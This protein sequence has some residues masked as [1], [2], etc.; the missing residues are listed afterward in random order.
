M[1]SSFLRQAVAVNSDRHAQLTN[2]LSGLERIPDELKEQTSKV[3]ELQAQLEKCEANVAAL[4]ERTRNQRRN[5]DPGIIPGGL[6]LFRG[7]KE[8]EKEKVQEQTN[9]RLF[10][11]ARVEEN[12]ERARKAFLEQSLSKEQAVKEGL[13]VKMKDYD[14][15]VGQLDAMYVIFNGPTPGYPK[16][17][18]LEQVVRASFAVVEQARTYFNAENK[19]LEI[20][21]RSERT[22]KE[23][24][25]KL[26]DAIY[27]ATTAMVSG[28][29]T[30]QT[31][32]SASLKSAHSLAQKAQVLVR[33]A[34]QLSPQIRTLETPSIVRELPVRKENDTEFHEVLKVYAAELGN[35]Y[36]QL[37]AERKSCEERTED[38]KSAVLKAEQGIAGPAKELRE[39]RK[40]TFL[41]IVSKLNSGELEEPNDGNFEEP[42][43]SYDYTNCDFSALIINVAELYQ[44]LE[45]VVLLY[46][47]GVAVAQ[48]FAAQILCHKPGS[49]CTSMSSSFLQQAV[50]ENSS[51]HTQLINSLSELEAIPDELKQQI[52]EVEELQAQLEECEANVAVLF[53]KTRNQRRNAD[54]GIIPGG[55]KFSQVFRG[56]KEKEKEKER[57]QRNKRLFEEARVEENN[58]RERKA[59]LEQSLKNAQTAKAELLV[60]MNEYDDFI[61]KLDALYGLIFNGPT[62]G[63][64]KEDELEQAVQVSFSVTERAKANFNTENDAFEILSRSERTF[65]EC[66]SKLKDAIYWATASMLAGG[67][68]AESKESASLRSA[69]SLAQKAQALV[70]DAQQYSPHV[71]TLETPSIAR[72]LP[73]RKEND[74]EFHETLKVY[75]AELGTTYSQ[76]I[77]EWKACGDRTADAK[78]AVQEAE[79][80]IADR[81]KDLREI[82]KTT[83]LEIVSKLKSGELEEPTDLDFEGLQ[84]APPSYDQPHRH[85]QP[86]PHLPPQL[87]IPKPENNGSFRQSAN[88]VPPAYDNGS[89]SP[90]STYTAHSSHY[91]SYYIDAPPPPT[92]AT[93][94]PPTPSASRSP[95]DRRPKT[96]RPLPRVPQPNAR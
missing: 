75:A 15:I 84:D 81:K 37:L 45:I 39:L 86:P 51:R 54:P 7:K 26:K 28:G 79:Q 89:S 62:P 10:E 31:K 19:A 88:F 9:N 63:Y 44:P 53:E 57:E 17:D 78:S 93:P 16:E 69:H 65:R 70:R 35:T 90:V 66:Q 95:S 33:E 25:S 49:S 80:G 67:R 32:E 87:I 68:T 61:G 4:F 34:Q 58:E 14:D 56:R 22:F 36:S 94:T 77:A 42:P 21:S 47:T 59:S 18:E 83:F 52:N 1:S 71:R 92:P 5:A 38:A 82:R 13:L 85:S 2:A 55:L 60:K 76:L 40:A 8:K 64:P 24:H 3:E 23:C 96:P 73:V 91:S 48:L 72:E 20:L 6:R 29:R 43:P 27:W 30:A 74:T 11:E 41:D 50:A 46:C 12:S